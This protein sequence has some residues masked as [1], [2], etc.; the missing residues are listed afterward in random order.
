MSAKIVDHGFREHGEAV[1]P[2]FRVSYENL[3]AIEIDILD[4]ER[5]AFKQTKSGAVQDPEN[6]V[7]DAFTRVDDSTHFVDRQDDRQPDRPPRADQ[8]LEPR[9]WLVQNVAI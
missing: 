8:I 5:E 7:V 3:V 2:S 1:A 4:A 9:Q 6:D